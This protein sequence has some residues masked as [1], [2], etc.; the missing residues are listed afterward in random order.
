MGAIRLH[1]ALYTPRHFTLNDYLMMPIEW[2]FHKHT[3][4]ADTPR[5]SRHRH[6]SQLTWAIS[7]WLSTLDLLSIFS[8]QRWRLFLYFIDVIDKRIELITSVW[9]AILFNT[10]RWF[11]DCYHWEV[12]LIGEIAF[13]LYFISASYAYL[14]T[15]NKFSSLFTITTDTHSRRAHLKHQRH[16][17]PPPQ[18]AM[19]TAVRRAS[20]HA[21]AV[22]I[23]KAREVAYN[24]R[25]TDVLIMLRCR[26]KREWW[27]LARQAWA[28]FLI[29]TDIWYFTRRQLARPLLSLTF[30]LLP[31]HRRWKIT[32][33]SQ[34]QFRTFRRAVTK[35]LHTPQSHSSYQPYFDN[36]RTYIFL[37]R[38]LRLAT[39][40][41]SIANSRLMPIV[42]EHI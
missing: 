13:E 40:I 42:L 20:S 4:R 21:T 8:R 12:W 24:G 16:F 36:V 39:G 29:G 32:V 22:P 10:R 14:L 23:T 27:R 26:L 28:W 37:Q 15:F 9:Y 3:L 38:Q 17:R 19:A 33:I 31:K 6:A 2:R 30:Y 25:D 34:M 5:L 18:I 7:R 35:T 11:Q 1:G 41:T